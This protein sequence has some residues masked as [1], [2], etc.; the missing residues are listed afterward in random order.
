MLFVYNHTQRFIG[1]VLSFLF[2]VDNQ[3]VISQWIAL[4]SVNAR[5]VYS[6]PEDSFEG[7]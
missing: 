1:V 3:H 5:D 2:S 6:N 4:G 7:T